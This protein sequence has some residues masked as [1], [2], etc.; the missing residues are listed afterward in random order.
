M[1][2][3]Y[4]RDGTTTANPTG[5]PHAWLPDGTPYRLVFRF[6]NATEGLIGYQG[7]PAVVAT[8]SQMVTRWADYNAIITDAA[9]ATNVDVDIACVV[10]GQNLHTGR[11]GLFAEIEASTLD[12]TVFD[13]VGMFD[14]RLTDTVFGPGRRV[15]SGTWVQLSLLLAGAWFPMFTGLVDEWSRE[16]KSDAAYT[17]DPNTPV[18][19]VRIKCTDGFSGLSNAAFDG[20]VPQELTSARTLRLIT[21]AWQSAWGGTSIAAGTLNLDGRTLSDAR[22]L[23]GV[24][25][26]AAVEDGRVFVASDGTLTWQT[27][28]WRTTRNSKLTIMGQG[29][30]DFRGEL[31]VC[32]YAKVAAG[33]ADY[34]AVKAAFLVY[35]DMRTCTNTGTGGGLPQVCASNMTATD[36][37][38]DVV[39]EVVL[40]YNAPQTSVG[41]V[42]STGDQ[43]VANAA[44]EYKARDDA[45][46]ARYGL[47]TIERSDLT[48]VPQVPTLGNL[49]NTFLNRWRMG[50]ATITNVTV[51]LGAEPMHHEPLFR[52]W[53]GDLINVVDRV[54]PAAQS[55]EVDE[56]IVTQTEVAGITWNI[57]PERLDVTL[58]LDEVSAA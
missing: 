1:I 24:K 30:A 36:N 17:I 23:D 27:A 54:P 5:A 46:I 29:A 19:D 45:S 4:H 16:I 11:S 3:T 38:D 10:S 56:W 28:A 41:Y 33:Y 40:S 15:R 32:T 49:A 7:I 20:D 44:T 21:G 6:I 35:D 52:L 12:V 26:A 57:T 53:S 50:D 2:V 25:A 9:L 8:Y 42:A 14:P 22:V 39:N 13:E 48:P 34:N 31:V 51:D 58:G 18:S 47:R 43:V 37:A 55:G